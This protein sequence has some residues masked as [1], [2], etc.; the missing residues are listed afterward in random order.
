MEQRILLTDL[1]NYERRDYE[2]KLQAIAEIA[3]MCQE[4]GVYD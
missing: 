1:K 2:E 4:E 3:Q